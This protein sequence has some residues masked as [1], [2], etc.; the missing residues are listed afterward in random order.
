MLKSAFTDYAQIIQIKPDSPEL[1]GQDAVT[2]LHSLIVDIRQDLDPG[3]KHYLKYRSPEQLEEHFAKGNLA[4]GAVDQ[5]GNLVACLL[6][7]DLSDAQNRAFNAEHYR[8]ENLT[9]GNWAVHTVGV[10]K[11][12]TGHRLMA[13]LLNAV[14]EHTVR[15]PEIF[16]TLI[17]K[18][19][20]TNSGS[21]ANFWSAE[22]NESA[23]GHD[24]KGY[25]YTLFS[26]TVRSD[27][28]L[29]MGMPFNGTDELNFA[30]TAFGR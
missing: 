4:W 8:E 25:D 12:H 17:A 2:A 3:K 18:V 28:A 15:H 20:D 30:N 11:E 27:L 29:E 24:S 5:Q 6:L 26:K 1:G 13:G 7:S 10:K 14:H 22:F 16:G 21:R 23:R 9:R 19:A